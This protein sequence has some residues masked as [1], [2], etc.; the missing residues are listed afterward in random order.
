MNQSY[1][2]RVIEWLVFMKWKF[3]SNDIQKERHDFNN[4]Y[5][6]T[7]GFVAQR[8]LETSAH[9]YRILCNHKPENGQ[10]YFF[11]FN[12]QFCSKMLIRGCSATS[13]CEKI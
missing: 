9:C 6:A 8:S 5:A 10:I 3:C 13:A 2:V 7:G 11:M 1:A 12:S 4:G